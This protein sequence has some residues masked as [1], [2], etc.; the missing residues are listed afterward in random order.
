MKIDGSKFVVSKIKISDKNRPMG[1]LITFR[2]ISDIQEIEYELRR[3]MR[4]PE[5]NATYTFEDIIGK[6]TSL[7]N[8]ISLVKKLSRGDSTTLIQGDSGTGKE[9]FAQAIHNYSDRRNG[10]F[11]PVNFAALPYS[12]IESELFGYEEGAFTGAKKGKKGYF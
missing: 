1:F 4:K 2:N 12:L 10:P 11:V 6:S 5:H 7:Q 8:T 3:K 9:L